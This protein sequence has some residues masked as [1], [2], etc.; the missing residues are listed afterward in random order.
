MAV[1]ISDYTIVPINIAGTD[2]LCTFGGH[3]SS[4]VPT[5]MVQCFNPIS[6]V[7]YVVSQLPPVFSGYIPGGA[8]TVNNIVYVFGGFRSDRT[9]YELDVTL[10]WDPVSNTWR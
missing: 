10:A 2:L 4:S 3:D 6:Q 7:A 5:L 1:P 9:P 8:A